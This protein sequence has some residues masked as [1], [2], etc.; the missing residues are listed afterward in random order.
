M[1]KKRLRSAAGAAEGQLKA[2]AKRI[3]GQL[4]PVEKAAEKLA[5]KAKDRLPSPSDVKAELP[6]VRRRLREATSSVTRRKP[7]GRAESRSEAPFGSRPEHDVPDAPAAASAAPSGPDE[8]WTVAD[9]RAEARKRGLTGYS[10]KS[11]AE[12]LAELSS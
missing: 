7:Q 9:L 4:A 3:R 6:G 5:T 1:A 10:R 12:L 8:S 11:K 2:G